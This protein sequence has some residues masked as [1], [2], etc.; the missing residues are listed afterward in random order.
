MVTG[1]KQ[2]EQISRHGENSATGRRKEKIQTH[3][4]TVT[5]R[6]TYLVTP[7]MLRA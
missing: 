4:K 1:E 2:E 6:L 5:E 7:A 3:E